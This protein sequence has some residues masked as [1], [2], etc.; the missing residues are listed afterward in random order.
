MNPDDFELETRLRSLSIEN[1][2]NSHGDESAEDREHQLAQLIAHC[3]ANVEPLDPTHDHEKEAP[4]H[5]GDDAENALPTSLIITNLPND[6]FSDQQLKNELEALFR[7]FDPTATFRYLR[8]FR[9]ARVD[10][11]SNA[12]ASKA[13]HHLHHTPFGN[14]VMNCFFGHPPHVSK[15]GSQFLQIPPP[16]RQFLI[17]PP[18]SPPVDWASGH[19][20][21]PIVNYDL[22]SAIASLGPGDEHELLP[23]E[24]DKP[25]IVVHIC[26]DAEGATCPGAKRIAPAG[27]AG[28]SGGAIVHTACPKR[29]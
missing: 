6:L 28:S 7:T 16:V 3:V 26:P 12:L 10:L 25:G 1:S 9:R 21:E 29:P 27:C 24:A 4:L 15:N 5:D 13:R 14:S 19:E 8:S 20:A 2:T 18:A 22:L 23:A 11:S 17:S